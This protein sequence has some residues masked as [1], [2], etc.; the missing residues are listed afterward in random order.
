MDKRDIGILLVIAPLITTLA[1]AL[2][3]YTLTADPL[4]IFIAV[5]SDSILFIANIGLYL[6]GGYLIVTGSSQDVRDLWIN[7]L[8]FIVPTIIFL[9]HVFYIAAV[10]GV[11]RLTLLVETAQFPLYFAF[12]TILTGLVVLLSRGTPNKPSLLYGAS[13]LALVL[14][15][16]VVRIVIGIV[17]PV[18]Y[19]FIGLAIA[20][21]LILTKKLFEQD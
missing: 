1:R 20:M 6:L 14:L 10:A 16:G 2:Y 12:V 7:I 8:Y 3:Q 4:D 19:A 21:A 13:F 17:A 5:G 9:G 15:Y 18:V 11:A